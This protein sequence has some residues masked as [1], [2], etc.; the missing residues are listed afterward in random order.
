MR[1]I[2]NTATNGSGVKKIDRT[3]Y[4]GFHKMKNQIE[5]SFNV[6]QKIPCCT[7]KPVTQFQ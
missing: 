4:N 5:K 1:L 3:K 6:I 2:F 7:G